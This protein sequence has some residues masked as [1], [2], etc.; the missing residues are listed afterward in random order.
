VSQLKIFNV[1]IAMMR[2]QKNGHADS[3]DTRV[4]SGKQFFAGQRTSSS[5]K[6]DDPVFIDASVG[7]AR[8]WRAGCPAFAGHDG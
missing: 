3:T 5:A 4:G 8:L 2:A 6:A 1:S 7:N